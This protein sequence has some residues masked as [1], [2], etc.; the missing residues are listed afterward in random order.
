MAQC[1]TYG[2]QLAVVKSKEENDFLAAYITANASETR[3]F[4]GVFYSFK[5]KKFK[6]VDGMYKSFINNRATSAKY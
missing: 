2:A 6:T 5:E 1:E 3:W 4:I